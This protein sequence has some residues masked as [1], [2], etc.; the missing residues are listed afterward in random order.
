MNVNSV[1]PNRN[2]LQ[3]QNVTFQWVAGCFFAVFVI[4]IGVGWNIYS[5]EV[6]RIDR[7]EQGQNSNADRLARIETK[8]DYLISGDKKTLSWQQKD[9]KVR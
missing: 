9:L 8:L 4:L 6:T 2:D 1:A 7:I 5:R 3:V